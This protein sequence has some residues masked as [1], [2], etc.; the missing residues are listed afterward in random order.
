MM[1][2]EY[3]NETRDFMRLANCVEK[4]EIAVSRLENPYGLDDEKILM[5]Q[6]YLFNQAPKIAREFIDLNRLQILPLLVKYR[7]IKKTNILRLTDYAREKKKNDIL[8][9]L[10]EAGHL[11]KTNPKALNV[12]KKH[13]PGKSPLPP[14]ENLCDYSAAKPGQ[15]VWLGK[16]FMPWLVL[17]N[18]GKKLLLISRYVIDCLPF[19]TFYYGLT[20]YITWGRSTVRYKLNTEYY[21]NL[22]TEVEKTRIIPVYISDDDSLSFEKVEGVTEDRIFFLSV[23]EAQRYL[24][25]ERDRLA[26]ITTF[27]NRSMLWTLFDQYAHWWLRTDGRLT[28]DK[29]YVRDGVIMSENST[30]SGG[31]FEHFGVRPAV[32]I[33]LE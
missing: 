29:Y 27:A 19:E 13:I 31:R 30:V 33:A 17:E 15:T 32:Y 8:F 25:T 9:Y 7:V 24:R 18:S 2:T 1:G 12:V 11:L 16:K 3:F 26:P 22:F 14:A 28:A 10:M 20:D 21:H 6:D 4:V 5:Y 23:K